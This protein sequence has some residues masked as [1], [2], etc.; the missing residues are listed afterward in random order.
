MACSAISDPVISHVFWTQDQGGGVALLV[1]AAKARF[2]SMVCPYIDLLT[3][4]C[5]AKEIADYVSKDR[6]LYF[7]IQLSRNLFHWVVT[8]TV[9]KRFY[10]LRAPTLNVKKIRRNYL[11]VK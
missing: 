4:L 7:L 9:E 10:F 8:Q 6:D 1:N 11:V 3:N 5:T 2:P